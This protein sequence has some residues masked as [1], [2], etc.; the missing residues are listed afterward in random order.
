[1]FFYG[2]LLPQS[3]LKGENEHIVIGGEYRVKEVLY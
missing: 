2:D 3:I 1:V